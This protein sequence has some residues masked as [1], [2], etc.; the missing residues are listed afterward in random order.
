M[1]K[2]MRLYKN[3]VKVTKVINFHVL[4]LVISVICGV[5][6]SVLIFLFF[7]GVCILWNPYAPRL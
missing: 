5:L 4:W 6:D 3:R 1:L 7:A 2:M